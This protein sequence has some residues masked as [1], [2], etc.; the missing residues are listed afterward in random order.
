MVRRAMICRAGI[1]L[2]TEEGEMKWHSTTPG[3]RSASHTHSRGEVTVTPLPGSNV[4]RVRILRFDLIQAALRYIEAGK[5]TPPKRTGPMR[6]AARV[7][8]AILAR[9]RR[10]RL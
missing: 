5:P 3:R 10:G 6:P 7:A 9:A 4:V 8:N 1:D 2:T